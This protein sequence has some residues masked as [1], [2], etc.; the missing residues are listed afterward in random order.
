MYINKQQ[1]GNIFKNNKNL[2][3][4]V[5]VLNKFFSKYEVNTKERI[6]CFLGQ[7]GHESD[8]MRVF[9]E[10]L[11]YSASG[12]RLVFPKYFPTDA[13]ANQYQRKPEAI[14]NRVYASRMGNGPE[15]SGDGFKYRGRGAIQLTGKNNYSLFSQYIGKTLPET[16]KYLET[17]EGA[18]E[19]SF[20]FWRVN[21]LNALADVKDFV[22][23]T[24]RI[25]G[26]IKGL[27]HR[28]QLYKLAIA[29]L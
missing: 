29:A 14:A 12:L 24:K 22:T 19:S 11:N 17:V 2:D 26:G 27:E 7:V 5:D 23:L 8:E 10:N 15:A 25:N 21:K 4:L 13:L 28:T 16:I 3:Q 1:L 20:W 6:A 9:K 18:V